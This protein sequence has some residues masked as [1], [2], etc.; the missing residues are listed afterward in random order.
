MSVDVRTEDLRKTFL[1]EVSEVKLENY[2]QVG[3][4]ISY[5]KLN[6]N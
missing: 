3:L 2:L 5:D 6:G 1:A 4:L